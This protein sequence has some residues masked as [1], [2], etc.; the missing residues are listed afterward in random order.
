MLQDYAFFQGILLYYERILTV[1]RLVLS[2][3]SQQKI[4][5]YIFTF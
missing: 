1:L 2:L 3:A 4:K 5:E